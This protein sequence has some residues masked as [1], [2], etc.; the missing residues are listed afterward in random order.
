MVLLQH[1]ILNELGSFANDLFSFGAGVVPVLV[2]SVRI[3]IVCAAWSGERSPSWMNLPDA[4]ARIGAVVERNP[5]VDW[6]RIWSGFGQA[7][8]AWRSWCRC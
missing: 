6:G 3:M 5:L 1:D 4:V 7:D 2:L 8:T